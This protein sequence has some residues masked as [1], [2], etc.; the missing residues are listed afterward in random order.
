MDTTKRLTKLIIDRRKKHGLTRTEF[1]FMIN[2]DI[3]SWSKIERGQ[4]KLPLTIMDKVARLLDFVGNENALFRALV[5][6]QHKIIPDACY[7]GSVEYELH[8]FLRSKILKSG[9]YLKNE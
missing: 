6:S 2:H 1:A 5:Y 8:K 4:Q 3:S 9:E 7:K